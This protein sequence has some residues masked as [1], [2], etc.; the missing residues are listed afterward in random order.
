M[1]L[2]I[3]GLK[4]LCLANNQLALDYLDNFYKKWKNNHLVIEKWFEM[5]STL[6]IGSQGLNLIKHLL[7]HKD[8]DYK[9]LKS[10]SAE[11]LEKL[12]K[13]KPETISQASRISGV[14]PNDISVLLVYM[15]R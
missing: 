3:I 15:G 7:K 13:I 8:F 5:M 10:I 9:K 11:A 2:S 1:T 12:N 4:S 6:N 14:S